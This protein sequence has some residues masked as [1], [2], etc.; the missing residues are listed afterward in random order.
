MDFKRFVETVEFLEIFYGLQKE[1]SGF[2]KESFYL[3]GYEIF[4]VI[5]TPLKF[6]HRMNYATM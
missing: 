5:R 3:Y 1:F 6:S 4:A 2:L